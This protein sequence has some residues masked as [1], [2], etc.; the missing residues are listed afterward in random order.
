MA[1]NIY[2]KF[3]LKSDEQSI[4][5]HPVFFCCNSRSNI[6]GN[7][8][9]GSTVSPVARM[10]AL[11]VT[12]SWHRARQALIGP[13]YSSHFAHK[14]KSIVHCIARWIMCSASCKQQTEQD[15]VKTSKC[16]T[17]TELFATHSANCIGPNAQYKLHSAQCFLQSA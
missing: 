16:T 2:V 11:V 15:I 7:S 12:Q 8:R 14:A 4:P 13:H 17:Q 1:H 10:W 3:Y 9:W 5:R 6:R